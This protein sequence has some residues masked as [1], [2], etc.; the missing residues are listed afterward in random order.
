MNA[1]WHAGALHT[2]EGGGAPGSGGG[3]QAA[4]PFFS[5]MASIDGSFPRKAL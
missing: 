1:V 3:A 2:P 5:S 4:S